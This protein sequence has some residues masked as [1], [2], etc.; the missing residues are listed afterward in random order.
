M[1]L[2]LAELGGLFA[3]E[4]APSLSTNTLIQFSEIDVTMKERTPF[5]NKGSLTLSPSATYSASVVE[6][7]TT[8]CVLPNQLTGD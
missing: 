1:Y 6:R 7:V 3:G 2:V 8:F 5:T 4:I